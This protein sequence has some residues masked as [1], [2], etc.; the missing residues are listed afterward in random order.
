GID[1]PIG[2][3]IRGCD[4]DFRIVGVVKDSR[5]AGF[6]QVVQ[7]TVYSMRTACNQHKTEVLVKIKPG[8]TR[9]TLAALES[10]WK[11]INRLDGEHFNY[12]FL[13]QKYAAL[14]AQQEQ[15]ESA[16][17]A[18]TVLSIA[19][20]IMGLFSMSAYSI[21]IRQKEMSIRKVLGASV[22]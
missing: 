12:E 5:I 13:D 10:N 2:K 6:Q 16:F 22:V 7:P 20:A 3:T 15:L 9:Q 17:S 11:S 18:F 8:S 19:I 1:H 14:H 21:R 4:A